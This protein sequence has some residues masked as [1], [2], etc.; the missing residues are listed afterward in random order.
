MKIYQSSPDSVKHVQTDF[1]PGA[2]P[3]PV[4]HTNNDR[5]HNK[6]PHRYVRLLFPFP[7]PIPHLTSPSGH[8]EPT[9]APEIQIETLSGTSI[10]NNSFILN[11]VCHNCRSWRGGSLDVTSTA[12][13]WIYALGPNLELQSDALDAPLRRHHAYGMDSLT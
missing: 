13:P 11:A 2:V 5:C 1:G 6:S 4:E 12:Q 7:A 8:S 10:T 9:Y 3:Y